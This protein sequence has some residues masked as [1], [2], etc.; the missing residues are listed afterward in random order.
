MF[1]RSMCDGAHV[2]K[3]IGET[4]ERPYS[5]SVCRSQLLCV[6]FETTRTQP[7]QTPSG[8]D[9]NQR[10]ACRTGNGATDGQFVRKQSNRRQCRHESWWGCRDQQSRRRGEQLRQVKRRYERL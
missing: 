6:S 7:D 8:G 2:K 1:K 5:T 4:W 9:G 10:N 3:T